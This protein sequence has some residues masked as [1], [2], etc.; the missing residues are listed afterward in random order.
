VFNPIHHLELPELFLEYICSLTG[1]SPSTTGAGSEGALTKG[2]FNA[3]PPI[4]DLNAAL[5]A[6]L[7]TRQPVFLTA[8]GHIG[9][10]MRVDHDVSLLVPEVW[11]RMTP[12][13]RLPAYL[14]EHGCLERVP[15]IE[16]ES[17]IL[18]SSRLGWRI[19]EAFVRRF[20]ARVFNYPHR[21]F[22]E[23][24][25]R[26]ETQDLAAFADGMD[27]IVETQ[28]SVSEAYFADGGIDLACPP[29]RAL[30]HI[31]R[32]GHF[33]GK[34][35][36][37]PAVRELFNPD[38]AMGSDWYRARLEATASVDRELWTRH[39][40]NLGVFIDRPQN[41]ETSQRLGLPARLDAASEKLREV[42]APG[43]VESLRGTIGT[44][45]LAG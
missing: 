36:N 11:S 27:N 25:L 37:D 21:V 1:K 28:R 5:V 31:M 44:Q 45:P 16:F 13:E 38:Q 20:L 15:D 9:P 19:T 41:R 6:H 4:I 30:L 10:K 32:D 24:L 43:Y 26:P 29:L 14:I 23:D 42:G 35:L 17:R 12:A 22:T 18:P 7:L 8:A 3:L 39:V 34:S 33:E 2:P 40:K